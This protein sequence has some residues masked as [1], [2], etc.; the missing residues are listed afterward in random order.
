MLARIAGNLFWLSRYLERADYVAR[1]LQ[2]AGH[3]SALR[4]DAG[5][6]SEWESAIVAASV[7][8]AFYASHGPSE[9]EVVDYLAF[10]PANPSSIVSCIETARRN[11]RAVRTALTSE[12]WEAV[13]GTWLELRRFRRGGDGD[14]LLAFYDWVKERVGLFQGVYANTMLRM[15]TFH[16]ARIGQFLER[17]D[18]SA[19]LLDVKYHVRLPQVED[20]GGVLDYYQWLAILRVVSA[21]RAYRVLY[22]GTVQPWQ[23]AELLVLRPEFPRSL[24]YCYQRITEHLDHI[25]HQDR[26]RVAEAKRHAHGLHVQLRHDNIEAVMAGGLH[27][28]LGD[29]MARNAALAGEI[30]RAHHF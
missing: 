27:E 15:D 22:Q 19:R 12:M 18:N 9:A 8:E 11:A 30:A 21:R 28:Y 4:S 14:E 25:E 13:N 6:G 17:A 7:G 26:R 5:E 20:V 1:L 2:A 23:V 3:M 24:L 29:I 10:D 16:F